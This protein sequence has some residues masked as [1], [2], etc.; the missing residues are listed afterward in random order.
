[1]KIGRSLKKKKASIQAFRSQG[2]NA[3]VGNIMQKQIPMEVKYA[4]FPQKREK[5]ITS[6]LNRCEYLREV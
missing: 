1:M 3:Y 5:E 4:C 6:A 2:N